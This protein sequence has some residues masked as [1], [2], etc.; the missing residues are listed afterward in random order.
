VD[1]LLDLVLRD[2]LFAEGHCIAVVDGISGV[3][4]R[5]GWYHLSPGHIVDDECLLAFWDCTG[6]MAVLLSLLIVMGI[7]HS[8]DSAE[9]VFKLVDGLQGHHAIEV[10]QLV[11]EGNERIVRLIG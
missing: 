6:Q 7:H 9:L 11:L 1:L 4:T 8:E 10:C 2:I 3:R 5:V